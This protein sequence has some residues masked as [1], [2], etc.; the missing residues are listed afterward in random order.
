M[1]SLVLSQG[2]CPWWGHTGM[3]FLVL[4]QGRCHWAAAPGHLAGAGDNG[5]CIVV[6]VTVCVTE[7]VRAD[8]LL[9]H[10]LISNIL[11]S[12]HLIRDYL[13]SYHVLAV[14]LLWL[15]SMTLVNDNQ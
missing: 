1:V 7:P 9:I 6:I 11:E 10:H 2:W 14:T 13:F 8:D 3:V 15:W 4:S 5:H 12:Q